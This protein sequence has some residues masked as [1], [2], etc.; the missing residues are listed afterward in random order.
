MLRDSFE[1]PKKEISNV[2]SGCRGLGIFENAPVVYLHRRS[3]AA[4]LEISGREL[5][6]SLQAHPVLQVLHIPN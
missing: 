1:R 2:L 5:L 4:V 6:P 3:R